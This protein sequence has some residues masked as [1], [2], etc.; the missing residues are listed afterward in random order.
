MFNSMRFSLNYQIAWV[1]KFFHNDN[2]WD[3]FKKFSNYKNIWT[4]IQKRVTITEKNKNR[5]IIAANVIE[6][7]WDERETEILKI[8]EAQDF[9]HALGQVTKKYSYDEVIMHLS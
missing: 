3:V 4:A 9:T 2:N 7:N 6:I 5:N 8:N 1:F